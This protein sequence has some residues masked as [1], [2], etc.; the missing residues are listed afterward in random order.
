[1][2]TFEF[3]VSFLRLANFARYLRFKV[4]VKCKLHACINEC[5][6][7]SKLKIYNQTFNY[8]KVWQG[9]SFLQR[10]AKLGPVP[11]HPIHFNFE[12]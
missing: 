2:L 7:R 5:K 8:R 4:L 1:M 9:D 6:V 12:N 11:A 3:P 10:V